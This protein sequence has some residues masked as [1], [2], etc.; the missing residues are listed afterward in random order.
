MTYNGAN[1]IILSNNNLQIKTSINTFTEQ[2]PY[3]YQIIDNK[4][5][6]VACYFKLKNNT[7][8]F[9]FPDGYNKN[10]ELSN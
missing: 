5:Q 1:N 4:E 10:Y 8:S 9:D 2:K 3:A 6:E 7:V